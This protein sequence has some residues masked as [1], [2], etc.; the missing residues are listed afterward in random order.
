MERISQPLL[1]NTSE[2]QLKGHALNDN[3]SHSLNGLTFLWIVLLL[4][5]R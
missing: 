4:R 5:G 1:A 2:T 3:D